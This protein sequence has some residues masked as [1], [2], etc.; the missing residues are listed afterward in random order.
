MILIF[1]RRIFICKKDNDGES[2]DYRIFDDNTKRDEYVQKLIK[3]ITEE[4]F[5]G[6]MK[7]EI[8]KMCEVSDNRKEYVKRIFAGKLQSTK[9]LGIDKRFLAVNLTNNDSLHIWKYAKPI[10]DVCNLTING[11]I[12]TWEVK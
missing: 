10:N 4:Q 9:P 2:N 11:E 8:G 12:Y 6:S 7:L 3:W 5:S 1:L